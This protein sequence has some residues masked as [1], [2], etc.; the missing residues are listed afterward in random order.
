MLEEKIKILEKELTELRLQQEKENKK[1]FPDIKG[2]CYR[3][4]SVKLIKVKGVTH[5]QSPT[6]CL[7]LCI[8]VEIRRGQ[9]VFIE[10]NLGV[11]VDLDDLDEVSEDVFNAH[12]EVAI[13]CLKERC[14]WIP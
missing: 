7:V 8:M 1:I 3:Y 6:T 14:R 9:H 13:D 12:V 5:V 10:T 4:S 11:H 2:K